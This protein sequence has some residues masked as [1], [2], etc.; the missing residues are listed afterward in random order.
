MG[1]KAGRIITGVFTAGISEVVRAVDEDAGKDMCLVG[2]GIADVGKTVGHGVAG[3][4][5]VTVGA[6]AAIGGDES[7]LNAGL[8]QCDK[9]K[10][11]FVGQ[12][13]ITIRAYADISRP[14]NGVSFNIPYICVNTSG[15]I[16]G[17]PGIKDEIKRKVR[18]KDIVSKLNKYGSSFSDNLRS[19]LTFSNNEFMQ[20]K[21]EELWK[22]EHLHC[23]FVSDNE[24]H[25]KIYS[26]F[27]SKLPKIKLKYQTSVIVSRRSL[28]CK[29]KIDT[30]NK[31][32]FKME[33]KGIKGILSDLEH[34]AAMEMKREIGKCTGMPHVAI[35]VYGQKLLVEARMKVD[36]V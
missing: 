1:N 15:F 28:Q 7:V 2:D 36:I 25:G 16:A 23:N 34:T 4:T 35:T 10:N 21:I 5:L 29:I 8:N 6:F 32:K 31:K 13:S 18:N 9:A 22:P 33:I 19:N 11:A 26:D 20:Q 30:I 12:A 3:A 24:L 14:F 17:L 27:A